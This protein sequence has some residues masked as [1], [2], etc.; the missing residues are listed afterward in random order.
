MSELSLDQL[1]EQRNDA[2]V[3]SIEFRRATTNITDGEIEASGLGKVMV[4][5]LF[6]LPAEFVEGSTLLHARVS[7]TDERRCLWSVM[8]H[9]MWD[10][11]VPDDI[12]EESRSVEGMMGLERRL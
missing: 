9:R 5:G 10:P 1:S 4:E 6:G 3:H 12:Q 8:W 2:T 7:K 11:N